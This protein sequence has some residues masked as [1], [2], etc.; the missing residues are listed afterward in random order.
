MGREG[1]EIRT[2][3][4]N[5]L[6]LL[7]LAA[8]VRCRLCPEKALENREEEAN[9]VLTGTVEEIMNVDPVHNTYSCKVRVWRYLKGR[10]T[11]NN[12]ILLDDGKR[13]MICGFGDPLICDNQVSTGDTRIFFVNVAPKSMWPAHKNELMLSSS[14]M[15]ITLRNLEE[16]ENCVEDKPVINFTPAPPTQ[17]VCRGV[18]CGFGAMCERDPREPDKGTCICKRGACPSVVAPVC[19]SDYSTY[20]NECEL[21]MA[22]CTQ[23]RRIKVISR[24]PCGLKD[25]CSDVTCGFGSSCVQSSDGQS[26]KCICPTTCSGQPEKVV[27]GSDG[28]DYRN[29]CELNK[30]ACDHHRNIYKKSDGFCDPCKDAQSDLNQACR[31]QPRIRKPEVLSRPESCPKEDRPVCADDGQTYDSM[32]VMERVGA[33][34]GIHLQRIRFGP[35]LPRDKCQEECKFNAV[36]LNLRGSVRCSCDRIVCDGAYKPVCG[37][38]SQSY[39]NDCERQQAECLGQTYIPVKHQGPCDLN[40]LSPCL[41]VECDFGSKCIVKNNKAVCECQQTCQ[42]VYEPVC[43][44]DE[45]IYGNECE[46]EAMACILKKHITVKHKGPCDRCGNC[47]FGAI[48]EAETGKCV[49][50]T[51]CVGSQQLVCGTDGNTYSN[52]CELHVQSCIKQTD[53]QVASQGECKQCGSS[54]CQFGAQCNDSRCVC[55][56]CESQPIRSVCGSDG[57]TYLHLCDLQSTSCQQKRKIEVVKEGPCDDECGS[58]GSGSGDNSECEQEKCRKYGGVWDED[59]EDGPCDCGISCQGVPWSPVCGSDGVTY[60][61]ECT[62]KLTR[63]KLRKDLHVIVPSSCKDALPASVPEQH[64]SKSVYGCCLDNITAAQGVGLAGCPS[65]CECNRYGSYSETCNPSTGQCSCKPGV[66]GLKCDRCEPGFWN[67]RGIVIDEKSGCTPCNCDPLGSVRDDCEQMTGLCSCKA[68]IS[69]MKCN[70]CPDGSKLGPNGCDQD[71][72]ISQTCDDVV[73]QYG[74]TCVQSVGRAYCECPS[75]ICP[76]DKQFKVCGS[77]GLTYANECQLKT[78]VCRQGTAITIVH[79]GSCQGTPPRLTPTASSSNGLTTKW[80][81]SS[82]SPLP[83]T[84][85]EEFI[86]SS[87]VEKQNITYNEAKLPSLPFAQTTIRPLDQTKISTVTGGPVVT[88]YPATAPSAKPLLPSEPPDLSGSGDFSGDVDLEASGDMEASGGEPLVF[89]DSSAET[90]SSGPI[91]RSTCDNTEFGCCADGKTPSVDSEGSNCPP[92]KVFQGVLILEEVEGQEL[93]Y[94]PEMDDPKSEL[95]GETARSIESTLNELLGNSNIKKDFKS[96]R[97]RGL[98]PSNSVRTIFEVHFDP[99]TRYTSRDVQRALLQEVKQSRKK[100]IVVKKPEEDNIKIVDFDWA[101]VLFTTTSTTTAATT[102]P[103]TTTSSLA[104]LPLALTKRPPPAT[105]RWPKVFPQ[106]K[107]PSTTMRPA[108]TRRPPFSIK[109]NVKLPRPCDSQ[110]CLHGGTC[111]DDGEDYTCSCPAGKGGAVCER[112]IV[113]YLPEFGG[114]SYLAFKTMKAYYTVRINLEFRASELSGLLLYNGQKKGKDFISLALVKGY[115]ELR[116]NTGSGTGVITSK[117]PIKPG[118]W[119]QVVVNRN[120]RSGMLSVD[121]E[122]HVIGQSPTGT[123][124]LNLDTDLFLGGAPEDEMEF[125]KERTSA[126]KGLRGCIRLLDVNNLIYDLQEKGSD[127][128][129]GSGVGECGNN[130][131]D[132]NPCRNNGKCHVK[133]AEMFHC[134]CVGKFSGP[135][136][137]DKHNPC[138]P[139]PCHPL[140]TCMVMPEGGAK[141]ECPMGREGEFCER[142]SEKDQGNAF[143][144]NFNG[145]SYLEMNGIHTFSD[146]LSQKLSMEVVFLPMDHNGMIFYNGQKTDGRGDFVSLN[147]R[148]G[149]LEFKYDLGKGPAVIRSKERIPLNEW[150]VVTVERNGRKGLM[151][152]NKGE[153]ISGESPKSRKAPHTGL[154]LKEALYVGGAPDFNKFARAA[155]ITSGFTGAI[156]KMSIKSI[157]LLKRENIRN[158]IGIS[159]YRSHPCTAQINPCWNGGV[160][161]PRL[162]DYDCMCQRG[163]SGSRCEK[164]LEEKSAGESESIAFNGRTFIE[165]HN[166]VTRSH[167]ANEIPDPEFMDYPMEQSEKAIQV[168]YFELSIKTEATQGLILWSGKIAERSDYIALAVVDGFVQMTYDLGSKPVILRST[169]PVNTNQ[170]V[171]IKANRIHRYGTLQ[172]GNEAPVTGSSPFGATQL[173]TDGALWLGGIEKLALGSRLPKAYSTGFIGCIKDVIVDRQELQLIEDALNNPTILHCPAKK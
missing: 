81:E 21:E 125:V 165:Y 13:V 152:I 46:L 64:C 107:W 87:K 155:A 15:R 159:N 50:S 41:N 122:P 127:V 26:A 116:F 69:R 28:Q 160:C 108:T 9:V 72:S 102:V 132:P 119:H 83:P 70:Q 3:S 40:N 53:I 49:C 85:S 67:F 55:P 57:M 8:H 157:P 114:K 6:L 99:R 86:R 173:D 100:S 138:D 71:P 19:G 168:N 140:A 166:S 131:C 142:E 96:V 33:L 4:A 59:S 61:N 31:V 141:C 1:A 39:N 145:Y 75:S 147:L 106:A 73:C 104:T 25:P 109:T 148:D 60:D 143:I 156:Q 110:P 35:C 133:E 62:L 88:G 78:I 63:C 23:Q 58:G 10:E 105:T 68:G 151:Q 14:L 136:C 91:E 120:R 135:T 153:S 134:E 169:V 90:P 44:S 12:E 117:T 48:C 144:P 139:K 38:N 54:I 17:D 150:N 118:N 43:G 29:E 65:T 32:C 79:Q 115:V 126:T 22:Q 164:A 76:K 123:D 93:F 112:T 163:F 84:L 20:S 2:F 56:R 128:L 95:F 37:Q 16:V 7:C 129:Y 24:G 27:C 36:C 162:R 11:V 82:P 97:V 158:A 130:P 92:T 42:S 34:K 111:E 113:Y 101:P 74:A 47:Q 124:G 103:V 18:L 149:Y 52:E 77:D 170:W 30:H 51:E 167:L 172:V 154:N 45:H 161:S 80:T 89:N 5:L 146:D 171:R 98:G 94:T 137:A 121:G 66:G